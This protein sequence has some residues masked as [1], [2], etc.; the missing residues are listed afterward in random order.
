M[1]SPILLT[2]DKFRDSV[3]ERDNYKCVF[4]ANLAVDSHHILERRLFENGGYYIENGASVCEK[5]HLECEM[6]IISVEEVREACKITKKVLPEHLYSDQIYDKWGNIILANSERM[7][8][9]LF[10]DA[11]VQKILEKGKVLNLFKKYYKY[12]RTYHLPHSP[13]ITDDDKVIKDFSNF[14]NCDVVITEKLDGESSS[15]YNDYY[16]AR[17]IDGRHHWS[18]DWVKNF[19][20]KIMH[21]IPDGFRICGENLYAKHSILYNDLDTY[22]YGFSIWNEDTC[23]DWNSTLE[24]FELIGIKPVITLYRGMFSK[25]I[26]NKIEKSLDFSK[27]EG[28]VLR[29]TNSFKLSKFKDNVAKFVRANHVLSSNHWMYS[30]IEQNK[31][32]E[33]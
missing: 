26:L 14:E 15:L 27:Q 23:L 16:H 2:R 8:G 11:S 12:P 20:S 13:G 3:L 31:L 29:K 33:K 17:S 9:E 25:E 32:K 7:K 28:Y 30:R 4:C 19:H 1:Y 5:H 24:Y 6:T 21:D 22:F 18:R 10:S